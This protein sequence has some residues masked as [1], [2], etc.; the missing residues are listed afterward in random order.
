M[1]DWVWLCIV[2]EYVWYI[3][4]CVWVIGSGNSR[5]SYVPTPLDSLDN[6]PIAQ[7]AAGNNHSIALARDGSVYTWGRNDAGQLGFADTY[8]D[9]YSMEEYPRRIDPE[10]FH[11][12][13]V[14][15]IAAGAARSAAVTETGE[16]Y[17]WGRKQNHYPT[18][19]D[20]SEAFTKDIRVAK[21]VL[22]SDDGERYAQYV[23]T[24]DQQLWSYGNYK[25]NMLGKPATDSNSNL[26]PE[27][28]PGLLQRRVLDVSGGVGHAA[29]IVQ[30]D[31]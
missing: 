13:K 9:I 11:N 24:H 20:T 16:L 5:D 29:A 28:V 22:T 31:E 10:A 27:R 19:M 17:V 14:V 6:I 18:R 4:L 21:V 25:S 30:L 2:C 23:L 12:Q 8:I 7:V 15:Y 26:L 1:A 3:C